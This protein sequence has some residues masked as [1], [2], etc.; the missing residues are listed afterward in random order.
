ML[1]QHT[2]E[3]LQVKR[4]LDHKGNDRENRQTVTSDTDSVLARNSHHKV[5]VYGATASKDQRGIVASSAK[6][7]Q[8]G[9]IKDVREAE[10]DR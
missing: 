6:A 3:I 7:S 1:H 10:T 4:G 2:G 8:P 5:F 9:Q